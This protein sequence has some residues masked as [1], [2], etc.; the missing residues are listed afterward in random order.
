M[1]RQEDDSLPRKVW[2]T[3]KGLLVGGRYQVLTSERAA[4][5]LFAGYAC[6]DRVRAI[7][8]GYGLG[9]ANDIF[10]ARSR[11][12]HIIDN[13]PEVL[14]SL[15]AAGHLHVHLSDWEDCLPRLADRNSVIFFDAFPKAMQFDYSDRAY[16]A[17]LRPLLH[18]LQSMSYRKC[19]F[20]T[21]ARCPP[22]FPGYRRLTIRRALSRM[23]KAPV[24]R[25]ENWKLSLFEV[26]PACNPDM[27]QLGCSPIG[28][29]NEQ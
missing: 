24:G 29:A 23:A 26:S 8:V 9:Y 14:A 6:R 1:S 15:K 10:A 25:S 11:E 5:R 17:Y 27:L 12:L 16:R 21:L 7:N 4:Q 13:Q 19:Y 22:T 18:A 2:K 28:D 20:V 3:P